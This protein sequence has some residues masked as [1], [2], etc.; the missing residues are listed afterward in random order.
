M[1]AVT[2]WVQTDRRHPIADQTFATR[3]ANACREPILLK[4]SSLIEV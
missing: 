2:A 4:N 3:A 1:R